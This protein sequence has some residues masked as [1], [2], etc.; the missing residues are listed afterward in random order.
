MQEFATQSHDGLFPENVREYHF[1]RFHDFMM[2]IH[3]F[4]DFFEVFRPN[5][6]LYSKLQ[7]RD[8]HHKIRHKIPRRMVFIRSLGAVGGNWFYTKNCPKMRIYVG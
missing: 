5:F 6:F 7:S 2:N 4:F 3:D 8:W 1:Y